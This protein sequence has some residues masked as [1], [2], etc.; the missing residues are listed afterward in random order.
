[1]FGYTDGVT[2]ARAD[3][4]EFF[5][6]RRLLTLLNTTPSTAAALLAQISTAVQNHT[7]NAEQFDDVTMLAIRRQS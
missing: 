7:G 3:D 4:D 1:L 2:E 5:N 6:E